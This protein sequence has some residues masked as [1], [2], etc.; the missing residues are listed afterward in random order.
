MNEN[1]LN[2]KPFL[3]IMLW[4]KLKR[5]ILSETCTLTRQLE[6]SMLIWPL[7]QEELSLRFKRSLSQVKLILNWSMWLQFTSIKF[8]SQ[9]QTVHGL[10]NEFKREQSLKKIHKPRWI[11]PNNED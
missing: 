9:I 4:L 2:K 8:S 5:P 3:E 6:T 1:T 10:R 11:L 7:L